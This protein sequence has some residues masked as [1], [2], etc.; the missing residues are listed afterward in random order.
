VEKHKRSLIK[1]V[2]WRIIGILFLALV[3]YIYT[4][5]WITTSLVTILHHGTF[6]V[7]YYLHERFWLKIRWDSRYRPF[8]RVVTYEVIL[9]NVILGII[10]LS[11]TGSLQTMTLITLTYICNKYWMYIVY[12]YIWSKVSWAKQSTLT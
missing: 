1:S 12:D 8:A 7:V 2:V 9:G 11:L 4:R 5:N 10:T 6:I 3:T